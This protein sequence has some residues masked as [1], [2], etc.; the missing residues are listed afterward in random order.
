MLVTLVAVHVCWGAARIP[1]KVYGRRWEDIEQYTA[2]GAVRYFLDT[3]HYRGADAVLWILDHVPEDRAVLW[4]GNPR[5]AMEFVPALIAPRL[6]VREVDVA[7]RARQHR[8]IPLA[9]GAPGGSEK[10]VL[11]LVGLGDRVELEV[12]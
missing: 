1:A 7:Q 9:R 10:G 11:V 12:R 6:L 4:R 5:R 8:G 3:G 2:E